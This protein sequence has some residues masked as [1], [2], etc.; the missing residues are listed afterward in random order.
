MRKILFTLF[1]CI[2]AIV[3]AGEIYAETNPRIDTIRTVLQVRRPALEPVRSLD[4]SP[5]GAIDTLDT[6]NEHVKVILYSD[7]TWKYHKL[8]S[9]EQNADV[10]G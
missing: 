9:F 1:T 7:N 6:I 10:Y 2:T 4:I 5:A 8:P 3:T